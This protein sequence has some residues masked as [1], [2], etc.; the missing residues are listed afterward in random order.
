M[1]RLFRRKTHTVHGADG[2]IDTCCAFFVGSNAPLFVA[3]AT[4]EDVV[5]IVSRMALDGFIG[6]SVDRD[7]VYSA[8]V[9]RYP[10]NKKL[11]PFG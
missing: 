3:G 6:D 2:F 9:T 8:L 10:R 4:R 7:K 11:N 5:A 1:D